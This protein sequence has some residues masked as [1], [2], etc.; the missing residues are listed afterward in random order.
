MCSLTCGCGIFQSGPKVARKRDES[1]QALTRSQRYS[2]KRY[3]Q[4]GPS[5]VPLLE[6]AE[7]EGIKDK[8]A[9]L[10]KGVVGN[11]ESVSVIQAWVP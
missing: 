6:E 11:A 7:A 5:Q 4:H 2:N 10:D 8:E 9:N 3:N 1:C